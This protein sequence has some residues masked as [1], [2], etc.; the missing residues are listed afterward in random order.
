MNPAHCKILYDLQLQWPKKFQLCHNWMDLYLFQQEVLLEE[1]CRKIP[2]LRDENIPKEAHRYK[3]TPYQGGG[4]IQE[5]VVV[6]I[7]LIE[8]HIEIKDPLTVG[9]TQIRVEGH[10]I[11]EDILIESLLGGDIPIGMEDPLEEDTQE[12][13]PLMEME[14]PWTS[15]WTRTTRSS[16]L[17]WT[18]ETYNSTDSS[19]NIGYICTREYF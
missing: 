12:E 14:D 7:M 2:G 16:R 1:E 15:W 3:E 19:G 10:L 4:N 8:S 18:G 13:D 9:D 5:K 11:E 17:P 6:M